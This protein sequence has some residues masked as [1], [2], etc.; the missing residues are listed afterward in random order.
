MTHERP[1]GCLG[2]HTLAKPHSSNHFLA[3]Y[4]ATGKAGT[5]QINLRLY[6]SHGQNLVTMLHCLTSLKDP[7]CFFSGAFCSLR[8][9]PDVA[10]DFLSPLTH[11]FL[12]LVIHYSFFWFQPY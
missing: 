2:G 12:T 8:D 5:L 10:P 7:L 3:D 9:F 4:G 1:I 6:C 11:P